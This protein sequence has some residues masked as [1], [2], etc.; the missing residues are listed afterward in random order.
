MTIRP[1]L[2]AVSLALTAASALSA[3]VEARPVL[4]RGAALDRRIEAFT[5]SGALGPNVALASPLA[6]RTWVDLCLRT[7]AAVKYLKDL[8]GAHSIVR[9]CLQ[10]TERAASAA[11]S[12]SNLWLVAAMLAAQT[13]GLPASEE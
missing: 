10:L 2:L 11:P 13:H 6:R 9:S 5:L 1:L 8:H 4:L 12:S 3:W 7:A